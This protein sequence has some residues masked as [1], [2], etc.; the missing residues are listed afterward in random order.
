MRL[1]IASDLHF[2]FH[3]DKGRAF[4]KTMPHTDGI[5]LA[6]DLS[7]YA[8][9]DEAL[10]RICDRYQQVVYLPGNHEYYGAPSPRAVRDLLDE[11]DI[12]NLHV[13]DVD[14]HFD[15]GNHRFIGCT[16]WF[17]YNRDNAF[18]AH[19]LADFSAIQEFVPWVYDE[20]RRHRRWLSRAVRAGDIVVTHHLP[21]VRSVHSHFSSSP[22]NRFFVC[23]ME[24]LIATK[25]PAVWIH[26]HT[27][28]SMDFSFAE[29][30]VLCNPFG[31][32]GHE[33]YAFDPHLALNL[34]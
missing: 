23:D 13:L 9:L 14:T 21:S 27:H 26:G 24:K 30:R 32:A 33:N 25:R 1:T 20:N 5:V 31:Y 19:H 29:T 18:H 28:A 8:G 34:V 15:L 10:R 11:I 17:P 4:L 7:T 12:P 2:E 22:L 3:R 6:G 16:L